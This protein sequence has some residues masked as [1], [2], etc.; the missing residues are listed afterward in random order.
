MNGKKK[1]SMNHDD[2]KGSNSYQEGTWIS[3]NTS[4]SLYTMISDK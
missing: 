4:L 2:F 3:R 1:K